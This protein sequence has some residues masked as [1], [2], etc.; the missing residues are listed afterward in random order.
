MRACFT[1]PEGKK[2]ISADYSQIELR[3][4][5]H[6]SRDETLLAAFREGAD[7]HARTASLLFDAPP[8]EITP[9]QRRNAKTINFGLIYG[10][11]PQK[12]AQELKIPLSEAKAFM[13]RYFERLQGLKHFYENVEEMAREQGYVTT[14]AGVAAPCRTFRPKASRRVR[15]PASGHQHAHSGQRCGHHQARHACRPR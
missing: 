5:A 11:G 3:V 7:I 15:S 13:A 8:S 14:L 1:A 2:L 12:L 10:M 4:L 6:L 9:D